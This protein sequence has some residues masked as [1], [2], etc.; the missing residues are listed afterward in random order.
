MTKKFILSNGIEMPAVGLG[1]F[2]AN[3]GN[4]TEDAIKWALDCGYRHID[5]AMIYRNEE[6][7]G[8]AI[9][10]SGVERSEIFLTT[11]L[12]NDDIRNRNTMDAFHKSIERLQTDY[13]DLYLIHWPV[14]GFEEAWKVLEQLYEQKK[15]RA[16]GVSNFKKHHLEAINKIATIKPMVNQIESN[17]VFSNQAL[18]DYCHQEGIV[19]QAW[20][21]LGGKDTK[22]V[23]DE[24][25]KQL[26]AKYGKTPA[27]IIIRWHLQRNVVVLPKSVHKERIES[28]FQVFDFVLSD[29][30]MQLMFDLNQDK[31]VGPDPDHINF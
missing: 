8:N 7:V 1:V 28:N 23:E 14:D 29:A 18:I 15:V 27:Q 12:W 10:Q 19:V 24:T 9:K 2:L 21:P 5:T 26:A 31:R 30:D 4:E 25:I 16:I 20:S 17:P 22:L 11:K 6:S 3:S 13:V